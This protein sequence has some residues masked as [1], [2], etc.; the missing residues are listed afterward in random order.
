MKN[1][2]DSPIG[3]TLTVKGLID[4]LKEFPE[5]IPVCDDDNCPINDVV[6]YMWEDTN[7]PYNIPDCKFIK[8]N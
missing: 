4:K 5:D 2:V 3:K 6:E 1:K 7:Y 8:L